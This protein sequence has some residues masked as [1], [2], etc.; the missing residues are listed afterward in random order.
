MSKLIENIATTVAFLGVALT[1]GSGLA[2]LF[3]MYH[4]GGLQTMTVFNGGMGLM[5]IGIVGK[6]HT[7]KR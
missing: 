1:I 3:G 6:L 7:L 5:L 4:L 2:R